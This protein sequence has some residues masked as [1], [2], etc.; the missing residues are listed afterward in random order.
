MQEKDSLERDDQEMCMCEN[1][2]RGKQNGNNQREWLWV[3][4]AF[5]Q[6]VHS[7]D[8]PNF[9][10]ARPT[11]QKLICDLCFLFFWPHYCC[12]LKCEWW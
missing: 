5:N 10:F 1:E 9:S 8:G 11:R 4:F 2:G 3:R 7:I 12:I 6:S